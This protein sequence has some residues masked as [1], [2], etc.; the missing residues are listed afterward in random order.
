MTGDAGLFGPDSVA[1]RIHA[2]PVMLVG[3]LRALLVQ[4]ARAARDGR[5]RPAQR[6]PRGPVGSSGAHHGAS[7]SPPP[8][9]TPRDA[10]AAAAMVRTVHTSTSTASTRSPARR[11]RR[12]IPTCCCGSTRS[13]W[14]R[15]CSRTARTRAASS[16]A[17]GDRYV[18]R[19]G[20]GRGDGR[21]ARRPGATHGR[22]AARLPALGARPPGDARRVRRVC[23]SSC[24]RPWT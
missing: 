22:R 15:S 21:A 8:T 16:S 23:A 13:R 19:D 5:G 7:C 24:S 4:G 10:E 2:D 6:V 17:D 11:T 1:W 20:A 9:A 18:A 3:G 12:A 14:S